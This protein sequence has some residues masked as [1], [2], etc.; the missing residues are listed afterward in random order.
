MKDYSDEIGYIGLYISIL[1]LILLSI[2]YFCGDFLN[3][4]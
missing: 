4:L 1:T 2:N 3:I